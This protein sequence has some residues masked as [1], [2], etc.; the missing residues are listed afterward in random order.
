MTQ[1]LSFSAISLCVWVIALAA[2][3]TA[4]T[5]TSSQREMVI[6]CSASAESYIVAV[7]IREKI[8]IIF[9]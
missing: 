1:K 4:P 9:I 6:L 5:R 3:L 8:K 2:W 7:M